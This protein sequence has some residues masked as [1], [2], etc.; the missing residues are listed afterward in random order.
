MSVIDLKPFIVKTL[1]GTN[2]FEKVMPEFPE[3]LSDF[4]V[5]IYQAIHSPKLIDMTGSEVTTE[6]RIILEIYGSKE[7]GTLS[8]L[9][10]E[11]Q[12]IFSQMGLEVKVRDANTVKNTRSILEMSGV[13]H[14]DLNIMYPN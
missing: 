1:Q 10:N 9:S 3:T 12:S 11:V 6:W 2:L 4:P 13:F 5:C 8:P 7:K 14:N